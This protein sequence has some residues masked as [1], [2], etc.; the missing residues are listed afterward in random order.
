[1]I[2]LEKG[3]TTSDVRNGILLCRHHRVLFD[4]YDWTLDRDLRVLVTASGDF[5]TSAE[6]KQVLGSEHKRLPNLPAA[7]TT[8]PATEAIEWRLS[9]F[10]QRQ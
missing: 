8:L 2:P 10:Q 5:R 9:E 4:R 6:A 1:L 3:G 7:E